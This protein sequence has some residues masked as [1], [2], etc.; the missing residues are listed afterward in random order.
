MPN[1]PDFTGVKFS[2]NLYPSNLHIETAF[3]GH[4]FLVAL[5]GM[6]FFLFLMQGHD[7]TAKSLS[8]FEFPF[9]LSKN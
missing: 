7:K 8:F 9:K 2:S 6:F 4:C 3:C 5:V 1:F